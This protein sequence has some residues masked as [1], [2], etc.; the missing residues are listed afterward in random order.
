MTPEAQRLTIASY[1]GWTTLIFRG[2]QDPKMDDWIGHHPSC[3]PEG[4]TGMWS[5]PV[6]GYLGD[7]R[8]INKAVRCYLTPDQ[9]VEW[10]IRL[11]LLTGAG[12][13]SIRGRANAKLALSTA[14][15]RCEAFVAVIGKWKDPA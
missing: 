7:E 2:I 1:C 12:A 3:T 6:P 10:G 8:E 13:D 15:H 14:T 4:S 9:Q 11:A 5:G